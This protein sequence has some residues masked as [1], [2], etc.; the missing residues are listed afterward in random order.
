MVRGTAKLMLVGE[1][2]RLPQTLDSILYLGKQ[3]YAETKNPVDINYANIEKLLGKRICSRLLHRAYDPQRNEILNECSIKVPLIACLRADILDEPIEEH[4]LVKASAS[5]SNCKPGMTDWQRFVTIPS[6]IG[7]KEA[8][9]LGLILADRV[10]IKPF[11]ISTDGYVFSP[12]AIRLEGRYKHKE[13][14]EEV[15]SPRIEDVFNLPAPVIYGKGSYSSYLHPI[16][17]LTSKAV[18]TWL[19]NELEFPNLSKIIEHLPESRQRLGFL[20]GYLAGKA[21]TI[22]GNR[23]LELSESDEYVTS[24]IAELIRSLGIKTGNSWYKRTTHATGKEYIR[25]VI[26]IGKKSTNKLHLLNPLHRK[27]LAPAN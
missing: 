27:V 23:G 16:I 4:P 21:V 11:R 24:S 15:I 6:E 12:Y 7:V 10:P 17:S 18:R 3:I 9:L 20:E 1:P 5:Y 2:S 14:Y 13:L 26:H 8:E 19:D 25:S 22:S